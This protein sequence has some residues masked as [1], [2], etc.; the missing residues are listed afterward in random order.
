M[1]KCLLCKAAHP[2]INTYCLAVGHLPPP[3]TS[4]SSLI[5]KE[6]VRRTN[7]IHWYSSPIACTASFSFS[8]TAS[9]L[10]SSHVMSLPH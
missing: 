7:D 6:Q 9:S 1:S 8:H 2:V 10:S 3:P 5:I 4:R